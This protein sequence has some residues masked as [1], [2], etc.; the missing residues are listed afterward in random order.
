MEPHPGY[1]PGRVATVLGVLKR[2]LE[3]TGLT[4]VMLRALQIMHRR[5]YVR[6]VNYHATPLR[7]GE[8]LRTHFEFFQKHFS[9][10]SHS[11][12]AEFL[13][14]GRWEKKKPGLIVSFD[15]GLRSNFEVAVPLLEEFGLTGWFFPP[16]DFV[17]CPVDEQADFAERH[18]IDVDPEAPRGERIAMTWK[19]IQVL[20]DRH[21][22]GCHTQSHCRLSDALSD[23][24]MEHEIVD[25]KTTLEDGSGQS[26]DVF[27]WVGGEESSYSSRAAACIRRAGYRFSFMTN[28]APILSGTDP[29]QLQRINV[30]SRWSADWVAFQVCGILDALYTRKR[31]LVVRTTRS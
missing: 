10:V 22:V 26:I 20:A 7:H 19:E 11:D 8:R 18:W 31:Q 28:S 23:D 9:S 17:S 14:D 4:P 24:R 25:A 13:V 6:A 16:T 27:C 5:G 1:P 12:L 30:D 15:D 3:V 21:V 2:S 29:L